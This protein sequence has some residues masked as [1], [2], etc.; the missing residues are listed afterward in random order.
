MVKNLLSM[1]EI[2]DMG[3]IPGSKIT[4]G[5]HEMSTHSS[6]VACRI[7]WTEKLG[8][9]QSMG[10]QRVKH[11]WVTNT[12][13]LSAA[14]KSLQSCPTLCDSRD[15]SPPGSSVHGISQARILGWV[16]ISFSRGSSWPRDWTWVSYMAG[17]LFTAVKVGTSKWLLIL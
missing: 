9:L 13:T 15:C 11:N 5:V 4:P 10:S 1:Q 14:A 3:S 17:R 12:F 2:W 7:P 6:L 16:A 8:G